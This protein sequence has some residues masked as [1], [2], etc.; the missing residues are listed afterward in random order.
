MTP[1]NMNGPDAIAKGPYDDRMLGLFAAY[2]SARAT[3]ARLRAPADWQ[4]FYDE[5]G[6]PLPF[7]LRLFDGMNTDRDVCE[8]AVN[9]FLSTFLAAHREAGS[10][11][12][13]RKGMPLIGR[14]LYGFKPE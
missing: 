3:L 12:V 9:L 14:A 8:G 10:P 5:E 11:R 4:R 7:A 1:A 6:G 13:H 2:Q